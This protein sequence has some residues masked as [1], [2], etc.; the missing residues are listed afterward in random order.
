MSRLID[1]D[2]QIQPES[3][4]GG[5]EFG[6]YTFDELPNLEVTNIESTLNSIT[7]TKTRDVSSNNFQAFPISDDILHK[8]QQ[9]DAFYENFLNQV[10][11]GNITDGQLYLV[12]DKILKRYVLEG[13]NTYETI[14]VPRALT[15]QIL[16]MA[17]DELGHN[18]THITYTILKR[19]YYWKGL[20]PSIE[21]HIKMCYQFQRKNKQVVKY[22]TLHFDGATFPLQF[23][24]MDLIGQFHPPT[25]RKHRCALT[26]ICMLTGYVFCVPLKTKTT[27]VIQAYIDNAY[28]KFGGS[29]KMLSDNGTKFKN[30]MFEQVAKKLGLEYKLYT[31]PY[32]PASNGRIEGF[33]AFLKACIAKHVVPQLEWD[34]L[35]S[36][37]CAA[38][39]FIPNEHSKESPFFLMFGRDPV[40]PLHILLGPKMRYLGNDIN[41]L[42]LEAM[43]NMFDIAATN[44][45]I[46]REKG[47]PE[48]NSLPTKLQPGST[49]LVQNHTKGPF[50]P[51]YVGDY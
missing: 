5:Y 9:E 21:K 46:A 3:D 12:K 10:E 7:D 42:S 17:H 33:H 11:K 49:V 28:P 37:A 50:D 35:I 1:I 16:R 41:I 30:K 32:H 26:V 19:L 39:N 43:K 44:L 13:D 24:S 6:Y 45:K 2:P 8:L 18:G 31:P 20:K 38:Y 36:L 14:V 51:K 48:N 22:A 47:N 34:V 40:L 23:I 27:E 29:L 25:S 4:P 15:A